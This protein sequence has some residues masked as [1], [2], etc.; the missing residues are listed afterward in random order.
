MERPCRRE[1][2]GGE[3]RLLQAKAYLVTL[4]SVPLQTE[5]ISADLLRFA[6]T[7]IFEEVA[8]AHFILEM[9]TAGENAAAIVAM[10]AEQEDMPR[11]LEEDIRFTQQQIQENFHLTVAAAAGDPHPDIEGIH[12]SYQEALEAVSYQ[13]AGQETDL[14]FYRD[15]RDVQS[16][17]TFP[18]DEERKLIDLIA[19]GK[20]REARQIIDQ[21]FANHLNQG[22]HPA[23]VAKCL[24]YDMMSALIKGG[25]LVGVNGLSVVRF[26][27]V[28]HCQAD[29]LPEKLGEFVDLLCEKIRGQIQ[30]TTPVGQLCRDVSSY[31]Q[32]NY[33]NPD[34][35]ISQTGMHFDLTPA[36]LSALFKRETGESL[37]GFIT[38]VR[39][40]AAKKLL[41]QG[42]SVT[43]IAEQCGFRDSSTLIRVFKK[44][45]GLTPGQYKGIH[46]EIEKTNET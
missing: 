39:L 20:N 37:L 7:N 31:I 5:N 19:A 17:Y 24:A 23:S 25:N 12:Y 21:A 9:T 8:G 45:T 22:I 41:M 13:R 6:V 30:Q 27:E 44:A 32:E 10:P 1:T 40:D 4:F 43:H 16:G 29:E 14:V 36:Y 35:N 15:I 11:A 2:V 18:L 46:T 28:E 38:R 34:L 26:V 3:S 33:Q 42:Q